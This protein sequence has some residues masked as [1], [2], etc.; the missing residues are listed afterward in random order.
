[1]K[2]KLIIFGLIGAF[3]ISC[4]GACSQEGGPQ[5]QASAGKTLTVLNYGKYIEDSVLKEFELATGI[6]IKYEE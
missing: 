4:L 1:M 3:L 6:E 5:D 2:N